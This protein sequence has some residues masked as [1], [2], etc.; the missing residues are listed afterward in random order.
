MKNNVAIKLAAVFAGFAAVGPGFGETAGWR[1]DG[2]GLFPVA[3]PPVEWSD[4]KNVAWTASVG[5]GYS[6]PIV[7]AGK[8]IVLSDPGTVTC[9][10][11]GDGKVAWTKEV[12]NADLPEGLRDKVR[13][14]FGPGTSGNAAAVPVS[15]GKKVFIVLG[16]GIVAALD[17]AKGTCDWAQHIDTQPTSM[18]GRSA[19][20][21]LAGGKL[22]VHLTELIALDPAS[23]KIL[24]RQADAT[25]TYGSPVAGKIGA[26]DIVVTPRGDVVRVSDGKILASELGHA[27]FASPVISGGV[28]YISGF[29]ST[30]VKLPAEV[31]GDK[32]KTEKVWE[33]DT[34]GEVYSSP[35]VVDG[36]VYVLPNAGRLLVFDTKNKTQKELDLGFTGDIYPSITVA[37][38]NLILAANNGAM[39]VVAHGKEPKLIQSNT[40]STGSGATPAVSGGSLYV[41]NGSDLVCIRESATAKPAAKPAA[42][43]PELAEKPA[44]PPATHPGKI[45]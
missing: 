37:G 29:G 27:A 38:K 4:S 32:I 2:T 36:L 21:V 9:L 42:T 40:L 12:S 43:G 34:Q 41:R 20:P 31:V 14:F 23:G 26:V 13:E 17:L 33:G 10:N 8:V 35:A 30:G 1:G 11:A 7:I 39:A 16:N 3:A 6:C 19:S 25:D 44:A 18:E 28:V 15:D 22:I 5:S 45:R 24:W